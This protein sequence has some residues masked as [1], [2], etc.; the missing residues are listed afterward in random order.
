M[1]TPARLTGSDAALQLV[2]QGGMIRVL[3]PAN[4]SFDEIRGRFHGR[5]DSWLAVC[6]W[7][8]QWPERFG[9]L[10][11]LAYGDG[12][13]WWLARYPLIAEFINLFRDI[14]V[15]AAALE[16]SGAGRIDAGGPVGAWLY[17]R[18][19][20]AATFSAARGHGAR[21]Q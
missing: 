19:R 20:L 6:E 9:L 11:E 3:G 4:I 7:V 5:V 18:T 15:V 10:R 14:E 21:L 1:S 8:D 13:L 12:S 2:E 16:E 17:A